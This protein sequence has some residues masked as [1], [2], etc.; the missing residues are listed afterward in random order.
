M[1][2]IKAA[3]SELNESR[4]S[5]AT[6]T[7]HGHTNE[8]TQHHVTFIDESIINCDVRYSFFQIDNVGSPSWQAM[9]SGTKVWH[10]EPPPECY[11]ECGP[12]I[13]VTIEAGETSKPKKSLLYEFALFSRT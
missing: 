3:Q 6:R 9:I 4:V 13:E 7:P 12:A 5:I 10:L 11:Y 8:R 1:H 2:S